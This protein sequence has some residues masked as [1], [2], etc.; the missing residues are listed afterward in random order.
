[1]L[2]ETSMR[3]RGFF[4]DKYI[5]MKQ[6][7][8]I[9]EAIQRGIQLALDDYDD[10]IQ[11]SKKVGS[12]QDESQAL[13]LIKFDE[14]L[15]KFRVNYTKAMH[16]P[17]QIDWD[18]HIEETE[19]TKEDLQEIGQ[20]SIA[21][22]IKEPCRNSEALKRLIY[23][24]TAIDNYADLNWIDVSEIDDMSKLFNRSKFNGFIDDWDVS[25]VTN[26]EEMFAGSKFDGDI[27]NWDVS[28]VTNFEYM[29]GDSRFNGDISKWNLQSAENTKYMFWQS[30]FNQDISN[31]KIPK[32]CDTYNMFKNAE[33]SYNN[34]PKI[35]NYLS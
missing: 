3:Y 10:N 6:S 27:S 18:K 31:W 28:N 14:L 1:M 35:E 17:N 23:F 30:I 8:K 24:I 25:N 21:L 22:G 5:E 33:I 20:L 16:S 4:F 11:A 15:K 19:I 26:M 34:M 32:D 12:Y 9:L 29:F 2:G 13:K 7:N